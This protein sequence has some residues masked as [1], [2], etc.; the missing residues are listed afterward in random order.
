VNQ[1]LI[2]FFFVFFNMNARLFGLVHLRLKPVAPSLVD[3]HIERFLR[4]IDQ[5]VPILNEEPNLFIRASCVL[6]G[7]IQMHRDHLRRH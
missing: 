6:A 1:N 5:I 2:P 7:E 4:L 3:F